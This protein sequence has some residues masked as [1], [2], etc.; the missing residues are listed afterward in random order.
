M[1][2]QLNVSLN[3]QANTSQAQAEIA[4]L[5]NS[6]TKLAYGTIKIDDASI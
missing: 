1:A 4:R 6:L 5:S 3:F 2:K